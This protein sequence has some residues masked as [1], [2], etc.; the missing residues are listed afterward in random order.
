MSNNRSDFALSW[1]CLGLMV[2]PFVAG[3]ATCARRQVIPEFAPPIVFKDPPSLDQLMKQINRNL[4]VQRLESNTMTITSPMVMTKL[5]GSIAWERPHNFSLEAYPGTKLLGLAFAAGSNSNEF[6][7]LQQMPAPPTL[8]FASHNEFN[9]SQ[10]PRTILPVSPL[11]LREALGVVELDPA[12]QHNGPT[13]RPDG[14]V[15]IETLIP[16]QQD[17]EPFVQYR[18]I[19]VIDWQHSTIVENRLYDQ[20]GNMVAIAQMSN[21]T[22]YS[23]INASLPHTINIQLMPAGGEPLAFKVEVEF[24]MLNQGASTDPH[25]FKRPDATGLATRNIV[26]ITALPPA[27]TQAASVG[28]Q[29]IMSGFR[30]VR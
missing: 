2:I 11:W 27:Y 18:R 23:A 12:M 24:F 8:Y 10:E 13:M 28:Q 26:Q 3:G 9:A 1:L 22:L 30:S 29:G 17:G 14:K 20:V 19:L 5:S 7:L 16:G 25:A 6:W 15:Q 4:G 21:H